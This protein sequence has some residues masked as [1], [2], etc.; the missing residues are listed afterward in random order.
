MRRRCEVGRSVAAAPAVA[1]AAAAA[2]LAACPRDPSP[3]DPDPAADTPPAGAGDD[4][5]AAGE[6]D[7]GAEAGAPGFSGARAWAHLERLVAIGP[8]AHETPGHAEARALIREHLAACGVEPKEHVCEG[9]RA[10]TA[11]PA[12]PTALPAPETFTNVRARFPGRGEGWVL[13][14]TH[15]DSRLWAD[16]DPDPRH[17]DTPIAG[18]NDSGSSTAVLLELAT[19]LGRLEEPLAVGVELV[20]F[21]GEEFGRP[22]SDDYMQGSKGLARDLDALYAEPPAAA[23]VIDMVGDRDLRFRP[24]RRAAREAPWLV[25]LIWGTAADLGHGDVFVRDGPLRT[26]GDDHTPL[27]EAGIPGALVI[28]LDYPHWHTMADTLDKCA[29]ES[30]AITGEVLVEVLRRV[31]PALAERSGG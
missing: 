15:Y 26:I 18:A 8:R 13:V 31:G 16:A 10:V 17:H 25:D 29:P 5:A 3:A 4:A 12:D 7:G 1:V 24:E 11:P 27:M 22:G 28:D 6:G 9:G 23:I 30:L 21:D 2:L 19:V 14:G 20:F